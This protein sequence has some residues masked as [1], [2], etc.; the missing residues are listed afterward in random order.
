MKICIAQTIPVRGEI[1]TNINH[2]KKLIDLAAFNKADI[3][4]FPELSL[5]GY[6]PTLAKALAIDKTDSRLDDFQIISDDRKIIIGVGMPVKNNSG[7]CISMV[8]F[9]PH[10]ER[11]VYSK[12]YIH[13]DEERFFISGQN[14]TVLL[15]NNP[16][17]ALAICYELS[18]P[19]H[20]ENAYKSGA[21]IY[22]ASV[23]KTV[24]GVE[25]TIDN[26]S[27]I[28]KN[29]SMTVLMSNCIGQCDGVVCG[30]KSSV[31]NSKGLM[32]AQLNEH[33]EGIIIIDTVIQKIIKHE[34]SKHLYVK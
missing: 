31:W 27:V 24:H 1:E 15:N 20:P 33:S 12:K 22:I 16:S 19:E 34:I 10:K 9:H 29:Y 18:I 3:I 13:A 30:G 28:A 17:V 2:H 5:T 21:T 25:K 8:I 23:A 26:L 32:L 7:I 6:E 14:D 4:I 11:Q